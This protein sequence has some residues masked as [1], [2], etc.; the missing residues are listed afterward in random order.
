MAG[1]TTLGWLPHL[2]LTS[3]V[4]VAAVKTQRGADLP[5]SDYD[6]NR[7]TE[8]KDRCHLLC[9]IEVPKAVT[10]PSAACSRPWKSTGS[11]PIRWKIVFIASPFLSPPSEAVYVSTLPVCVT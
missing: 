4:V 9:V 7:C 1:E 2:W 5:T 11:L 8:R 10:T 3:L 6:K